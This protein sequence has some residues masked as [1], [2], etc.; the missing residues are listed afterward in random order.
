MVA[1][2]PYRARAS[3]TAVA[4]PVSV[5]D[6]DWWLSLWSHGIRSRLER[7]A[8]PDLAR[9]RGEML[10]KVQ[11]LKQADGIHTLF[12]VFCAVGTKPGP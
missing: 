9:V 11:V 1:Y 3:A 5:L 6:E 12:R 4:S 10:H 8:P 7:L 2:T